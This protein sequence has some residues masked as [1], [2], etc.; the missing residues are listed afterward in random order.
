MRVL[1]A[2]D[3]HAGTSFAIDTIDLAADRGIDRIVQVGDFGFWPRFDQ[4]A[5]F[6]RAVSEHAV[7]RG[8]ALWFCDGNH[9]DHDSLPHDE[10]LEPLE[11]APSVFWV[12][13]GAVIQWAG[14][15]LLFF[16]GAVSIDQDSRLAGWTWFADEIPS[17]S[18]W[19]RALAVGRVDVV[20]A[21]DTVPGMPVKGLPPLSIPWSA[22][23]RAREHRG[24]LAEL[25]DTVTPALWVHGHWHQ[26]AS[27]NITETRFESLGHDRGP[28]AD[29]I[30]EVDLDD[31]PEQPRISSSG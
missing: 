23:R 8:V 26:R 6:L 25:R 7:D 18:A 15:R 28:L 16:G 27:A 13:R 2:G 22:R 29:S 19:R 11:V 31:L 21:H 9:E 20:V 10:R 4:G 12:P 14:R 17:E 30:L 5:A 3:W 24:R 1:F